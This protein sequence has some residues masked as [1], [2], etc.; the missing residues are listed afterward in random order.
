MY[1]NMDKYRLK[2]GQIW[3]TG[4]GCFVCNANGMMKITDKIVVDIV[5]M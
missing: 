5:V 4:G 2:Y 1:A 3:Q